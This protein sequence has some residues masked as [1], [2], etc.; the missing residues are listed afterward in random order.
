MNE[1][2]VILSLINDLPPHRFGG[3]ESRV[4]YFWKNL[5]KDRFQQVI[6]LSSGL[7][8]EVRKDGGSLYNQYVESGAIVIP[9]VA[10]HPADQVSPRL[11]ARLF[12][13][14]GFFTRLIALCRLIKQHK[15]AVLDVHLGGL[16]GLLGFFASMVMDIPMAITMYHPPRDAFNR[17]IGRLYAGKA[18]VI[19]TDSQIRRRE[20]AQWLHRSEHDI[21]VIPTGVVPPIPARS[22]QELTR[23]FNL[24]PEGQVK[25]VS[26]I[27]RLV[28]FKGQMVLLDAARLVLDEFPNT[29]FLI[30]GFATPRDR[31]FKER[32][33]KRAVE[34]GVDRQV[35][36]Q[37]YP[38]HIGDVWQMIDIHA[39]ASLFDS[40]PVSI[41]EGMSLG[42]PA[43]VTSAGGIPSLVEDEKTGIVVPPGD[44]IALANGIKRLLREPETAAA[45]GAAARQRYI[46][47]Y[48]PG[49]QTRDLE[50]LLSDV[51]SRGRIDKV[52]AMPIPAKTIA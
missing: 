35:R 4:M 5:D 36:I 2:I 52:P 22:V 26:E 44:S 21:S 46:T 3:D 37:G 23:E 39:H 13:K 15:V 47:H 42:K 29:M 41:I 28:P 43:V 27:G 16:A 34:L 6:V 14:I 51:V 33:E 17:I 32:L 7:E 1:P 8:E 40:L 49:T 30:V 11:I 45:F 12:Y 31:Y 18:D 24:E 25:V 10:Q 19:V 48:N 20:L 38:G 50:T 9:L